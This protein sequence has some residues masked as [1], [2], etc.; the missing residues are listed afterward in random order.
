MYDVSQMYG[1][2]VM[3][4][5]CQLFLTPAQWAL[6]TSLALWWR[7]WWRCFPA[8]GS[9]LGL[10]DWGSVEDGR[11]TP[12]G[13]GRQE[14][15]GGMGVEGWRWR[16]IG[17]PGERKRRKG[18]GQLSLSS[19]LSCFTC[20]QQHLSLKGW[21]AQSLVD[22][23]KSDKEESDAISILNVRFT[24]QTIHCNVTWRK[25][26]IHAYTFPR[27]CKVTTKYIHHCTCY[28]TKLST[29]EVLLSEL[30]FC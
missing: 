19:S 23:L 27:F 10:A 20:L 18:K 8:L 26:K 7:Q 9:T 13:S 25:H 4:S 30:V 11:R 16:L 29:R 3:T 17:A 14:G 6:H 2:N 28:M 5:I 1:L 15:E 24:L 12:T 21:R 22:L